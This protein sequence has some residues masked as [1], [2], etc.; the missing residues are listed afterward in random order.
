MPAI[1]GHDDRRARSACR[2]GNVR[3]V[4]AAARYAIAGRCLQH[5][6]SA[7]RWQIVNGE[8]REDFLVQ[9]QRRI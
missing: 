2:F 8:P 3:I 4:D 9:Q 7:G 5:P 1:V 6:E